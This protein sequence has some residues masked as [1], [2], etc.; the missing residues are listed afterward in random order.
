MTCDGEA[1]TITEGDTCRS[2]SLSQGIATNWLLTDNQLP[3]YCSDFPN[4][5]QLCLRNRCAVYTVKQG[6][7]CKHV[8]NAHNISTVQLR[9][10]NPWIDVGC[11]N[12]NRTI[13][14]QICVNEPG[15]KFRVP[16]SA[17]G[18]P[19]SPRT[20]AAVPTDVADDSVRNCGR[21][22][23][24]RKGDTCN[25]VVLKYDISLR[26]FR[27]LNP[28]VD[29]EY[30]QYLPLNYRRLTGT[31]CY[32]LLAG[33]SYCVQAIGSSTH[34]LGLTCCSADQSTVNDYTNSPGYI[35]PASSISKV[36]WSS[37]PDATYRPYVQKNLPIAPDT[38][39]NCELYVNGDKLKYPGAESGDC[40]TAAYFFD[41]TTSTLKA[42]NPSVEAVDSPSCTFDER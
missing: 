31:R 35:K 8:A 34:H 2:I 33:Q 22:Y 17:I 26:D 3:A 18:K 27:I 20:T 28:G 21:Y 23:H 32:N 6:D 14:T 42:L 38:A 11:Y 24:V 25:K 29:N 16:S 39:K 37:L 36:A 30:D 4:Q 12:F 5:G 9:T 19:S 40:A 10:Y 15:K 41:T 7:T 13:G 1:Y